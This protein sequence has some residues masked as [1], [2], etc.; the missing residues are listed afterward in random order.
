MQRRP[1][2]MVEGE[3]PPAATG[4]MALACPVDGND[5]MQ[6]W[7]R[8]LTGEPGAAVP[9]GHFVV[10]SWQ[11]SLAFGVDPAGYLA[12]LAAEGDTISKLRHHHHEML[13]A[14]V[15]IFARTAALFDGSRSMMLLTDPDGVVLEAAGDR[16]T[17]HEGERI[18]LM[19]GGHWNEA[20]IGTNGIGTA[21]STG[22]PAQ[23][24]AAEHFCEGIKRWTC[25]AAPIHDP[26][27]GSLLGVVDIS[28]PP[29][30]YQRNNLLLAVSTARQIE[31]VLAERAS[32]ERAHLLET[33]LQRQP[34]AGSAGVLVID[35][36]GRVVYMN[37][38]LA[39]PAK[40]GQRLGDF[41][42]SLF[43][44]GRAP[45]AW[46]GR[47]PEPLRV[48][49]FDPVLL[50]GRPIGALL[51]VPN[52]PARPGNQ[53]AADPRAIASEA[54]HARSGFTHII[55]ASAAMTATIARARQLARPR[56]PVLIEG[57]TGTGKEL[58]ARAIHGEANPSAPFI[59]FNCGAVSRELAGAEL[60]GHVRGAFTG[61]TAEGKPGR[62]E[63]AHRGTLC[64][65]E[66]GELPIDLQPILLRA[67]EEGVI[68]RL[69]DTTPRRVSVRL[70]AMTNRNLREEVAARRFRADLFYRVNVTA[71]RLP[72]LRERS[73]DIDLLVAH[74]NHT[75]SRRHDVPTRPF[76]AEALAALRAYSWPGNV[77][78]LRNLIE[79][80]L[81][82]SDGGPVTLAELPPEIHGDTKTGGQDTA[83]PGRLDDIERVTVHR[84]ITEA[85][86]N[87]AG[88]ARYLGISR[89]TLYRMLKRYESVG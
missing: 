3:T 83:I 19:V 60:F 41:D 1:P 30:T 67:L 75:M 44:P 7:E 54:D 86:G 11:R 40:L 12:P 82:A 13:S 10:S 80:L 24:H 51:I 27:S 6:A 63:L 74:F 87:M 29:S 31:A 28:G 78:E 68:Y 38:Q 53:R 57:E 14:A 45:E 9:L 66:I 55:G 58:L 35:R 65:D 62:F 50:D 26:R 59:T 71:I 47:L 33:C 70:L 37:G 69:G 61:A 20:V 77:R 22:R 21:I 49:G 46:Q 5:T 85:H 36:A 79:G 34:P 84:A 43:E 39:A 72:P 15:D 52:R 56:V 8:F 16:D 76:G 48:E 2:S 17:M 42:A 73:G 4:G 23:V 32:L 64:L 81:L 89:S 25:A 18:H 88:A